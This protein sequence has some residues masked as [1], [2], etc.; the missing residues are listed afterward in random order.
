MSIIPHS[1]CSDKQFRDDAIGILRVST[2]G[3]AN[4]GTSFAAGEREYLKYCDAKNYRPLGTIKLTASG[5]KISDQ[6]CDALDVC[7]SRNARAVFVFENR[8]GNTPEIVETVKSVARDMGIP[9]EIIHAGI[10]PTI[11]GGEWTD[12]ARAVR[13]IQS[14][15]GI[16]ECR[17]RG[18]R[19]GR[20]KHAKHDKVVAMLDQPN[21]TIHALTD[22]PL[23]TIKSIRHRREKVAKG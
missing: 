20:T 21:A 16:A 14:S 12:R 18:G 9:V 22:V 7:K 1:T 5:F 8:I 3:Q 2:D 6:L 15:L 23:G 17:L 13:G 11:H 19:H 10:T 4:K